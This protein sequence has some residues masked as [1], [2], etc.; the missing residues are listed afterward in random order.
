MHCKLG[1]IRLML[2]VALGLCMTVSPAVGEDLIFD[3]AI[4]QTPVPD[5]EWIVPIPHQGHDG[6]FNSVSILNYYQQQADAGKPIGMMV[7]EDTSP[8]DGTKDPNAVAST[9]SLLSGQGRSLAYMWIDLEPR[10]YDSD[11][12]DDT[13]AVI[14]LVRNHADPNINQALLGNYGMYPGAVD[15]S[16]PFPSGFDRT[17]EDTFYRTSGLNVAM[18]HAYP[19]SY[20]EA[21]T[22]TNVHG[23]NVSPNKR[24]AMFWAPLER[25]STAKRALPSGHLLIPYVASYIPWPEYNGPEPNAADRSALLQ[26][27]RLR[28]ADGYFNLGALGTA[29][30][31]D[32]Y[33]V[34]LR[35]AW[36]ALSPFMSRSGT[37]TVLN[38]DTDKTL[39]LEWSGI[40]IGNRVR[41]LATNLSNSAQSID[42]SA[43]SQLPSASPRLNPGEHLGLQFR[44][45][46]I[47][48]PLPSMDQNFETH[49]TGLSGTQM[50]WHGV[51][52]GAF[53]T[54]SPVGSGNDSSV[55]ISLSPGNTWQSGWWTADNPLYEPDDVVAY[56]FSLVGNT[57]AQVAPVATAGQATTGNVSWLNE[58]PRVGVTWGGV[59]EFRPRITGGT[60]YEATN[61]TS[62]SSEWHDFVMVLDSTTDPDGSGAANAIASVFIR[63]RDGTG[64]FQLL[65]FDDPTTTAVIESLTELPV[66]TRPTRTPETFDG[67][68]VQVYDTT[69]QLDNF[70]SY[71]YPGLSFD[72]LDATRLLDMMVFRP[73][74]SVTAPTPATGALFL[75]ASLTLICRRRA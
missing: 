61:F 64:D 57:P 3:W 10:S 66:I 35:D 14:D 55:A 36:F 23:S 44:V 67:W 2:L 75:L 34:E 72:P 45:S 58:G 16:A 8:V 41:V 69:A 21:H 29:V 62:S 74:L 60:I 51:N 27:M 7:E 50:G 17:S 30:D 54:V 63:E 6:P 48:S 38:T 47:S 20:F 11:P 40:Q 24:S 28:G 25:V 56:G 1:K 31:S 43:T 37:H 53:Q 32:T 19:Y 26:H 12:R 59:I 65:T 13:Q 70:Q 49:A 22:L 71:L 68:F 9:L 39:G 4:R 33:R 42:W 15:L 46:T 5:T 18:P 52:P 73:D